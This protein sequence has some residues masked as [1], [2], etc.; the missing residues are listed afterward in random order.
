VLFVVNSSAADWPQWRGPNRDNVSRE[1]GLLQTWPKEGPKLLWTFTE[2]GVGYS[3]PAI[4]GNRL[5][6]LGTRDDAEQVFAIDTSSGK[7]LW[8]AKIGPI[9]TFKGNRWGDGPRSTASV[10]G[11]LIYA[12]GGG[13]DL[14]CVEADTGKERWRKSMPG[15]LAGEVN[16]VG[17]GPE[18]IGWGYTWSPLVDGGHLICYPGGPQGAV[19]ALDKKTGQVVWRSKELTEQATYSSPV[20]VEVEGIR[21]YVVQTQ[22]GPAGVAAKDGKLLWFARRADEY[23][24]IV[25]P[26]PVVRGNLIYVTAGEGGGC[27]LI[28][29]TGAGG[30]VQAERVYSK[31][32]IGNYHG[33]VLLVED[34]VYGYHEK[35]SWMCQKLET[36][37]ISW[38]SGGRSLGVGSLTCAD[39]RLYCLAEDSGTVALLA[40]SPKGYQELGRFRLPQESKRRQPAGKVWTHPVVAGGR[41]YLRDQELLFCF[42][43]K[44]R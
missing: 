8:K 14:V 24:D 22:Y 33:G 7:E 29:L 12:L 15:D 11:G 42:D 18:K 37:E 31:K 43:I 44:A 4:V 39:G 27:D 30:Q 36:G 21:Q 35:R 25:A 9:F 17:G 23:P 16:P 32:E 2:A 10:D 5:F 1:T 34:H 38:R 28:K 40:A 6:L 3:G 26:T 20:V 19:A 13:G 41:L